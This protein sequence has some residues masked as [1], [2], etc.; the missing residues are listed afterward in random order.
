MGICVL[1]PRPWR[2]G[3]LA[4]KLARPGTI[5]T[6]GEHESRMDRS[7]RVRGLDRGMVR[8]GDGA[9]VDT[10]PRGSGSGGRAGRGVH[11]R[12]DEGARPP[13]RLDRGGRRAAGRLGQG[14]GLAEA[15]GGGGGHG[16]D[17]LPRRLGV[18]AVHRHR[19]DAAR[20]AG[21]SSTSTRRSR[22]TC[23]TS[24]RQN[25]F[26]KPI[27]LRQTDV[28]PLRPGPRAAGRQLLRPDEPTLDA[29]VASLNGTELVYRAGDAGRS[30]PTPASRSSAWCSRRRRRS[31]SPPV[32]DDGP[33]SSRWA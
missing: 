17:G 12:G 31:R 20:R 3:L 19:R 16:R 5:P 18:E 33:C 1:Q 7:L 4:G 15:E 9:G 32:G 28:P 27:T 8:R 26:D 11:P 29:D 30:I 23:P 6:G 25:P 24:S 14:F 2:R 13:R 22:S 21:R 10:A